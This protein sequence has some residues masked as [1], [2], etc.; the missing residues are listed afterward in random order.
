[1]PSGAA[2]V[3]T[4]WVL[5]HP[6]H[7]QLLAGFIRGGTSDDLLVVAERRELTEMMEDLDRPLPE[8]EE[9]RVPRLAGRGVTKREQVLRGRSR[10]RRVLEALDARSPE[11]RIERIVS[12][13][14]PVELM[15]GQAAGVPARW[16]LTDTEPN[17]LAHRLAMPAATDI[18]L[19]ERWLTSSDGLF[20]RRLERRM[21]QRRHLFTFR[22]LAPLRLHR[23]VGVHA[24]V[25]LDAPEPGPRPEFPD[26]DAALPSHTTRILVR[27]LSGGGI[28][29]G[30]ELLP[31]SGWISML[32]QHP[33]IE[34]VE[35]DEDTE[36]D[37]GR[38]ELPRRLTRFHAVVTQSV[39]LA[40]EAAAQGVPTLLVSA[41]QRGVL[42]GLVDHHLPLIR[43]HR[44]LDDA[45]DK[46]RWEAFLDM[47]VPLETPWHKP[48]AWWPEARA[49]WVELL[50]PWQAA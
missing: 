24:H 25:H 17:T 8:R 22:R 18:V 39:T 4:L 41:A 20:M 3:P 46:M 11:R 21:R 33:G 29:D 5:D 15:A 28:H 31:L 43:V 10:R 40:A 48:P 12:I 13:G 32:E 6:A 1:M 9:L 16:Y 30:G 35:Q 37:L 47:I 23:W 49:R 2:A 34:L 14:A 50:G 38:W 26:P 45:F 27:R 42:D 36:G 7:A 44:G 19:P